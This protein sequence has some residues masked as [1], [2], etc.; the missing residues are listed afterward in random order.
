M[1]KLGFC[2][3]DGTE[4]FQQDDQDNHVDIAFR[5]INQKGWKVYFEQSSES[6]P[7]DYLVFRCGALKVGNRYFGKTVSFYPNRISLHIQQKINEYKALGYEIDFA[8][9]IEP[10][11]HD[12]ILLFH[13][14]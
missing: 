11:Q 3:P 6:D 10:T 1:V 13:S 2:L 5:L 7:V 8:Q 4:I 12:I 9:N 14:F